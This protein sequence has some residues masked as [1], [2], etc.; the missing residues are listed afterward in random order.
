[1]WKI[2]LIIAIILLI[3]TYHHST[4][5]MFYPLIASSC[6][7]IASFVLKNLLLE[8]LVTLILSCLL[9]LIAT[10]FL[11]HTLQKTIPNLV[12]TDSL[13]N[14]VGIVTKAIG[15]TPLETGLV[16]LNN[17]IWL[18]FSSSSLQEGT[19]VQVISVQGVRL[20][21]TPVSNIS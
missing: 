7:L 2:W 19:S 3:S 18:A 15:N 1:M 8:I 21:V 10:H 12:N 14:Q 6:T 16:R 4:P 11:H 20:L 9:Y 17:E 5:L 13:I